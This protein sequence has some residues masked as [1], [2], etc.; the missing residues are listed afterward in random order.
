[1][2]NLSTTLQP[3]TD[4]ELLETGKILGQSLA[5][6]TIAGR[7][8]AAQ[9]AA[10]RQVRNDRTYTRSGLT[11]REF[12]SKHLKMSGAQADLIIRLLNEFGPD[13]FEL[14]QSIRIRPE[15][16]RLVAPYIKDNAL[17][18]NDEVLELNS[19]N[20]HN[21]AQSIHESQQALLPTGDPAPAE[22]NSS[23]AILSER[24]SELDQRVS[25]II[26]HF[27]EVGDDVR[28]SPA[29]QSMFQA[30]IGRM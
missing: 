25:E 24:L 4:D 15:K 14:T 12:S 19:A 26:G 8:S 28:H 13:Y 5:F 6:G 1:M 22:D 17:H 11:W 3:S 9:A 29:L 23:S 30:A 2:M 10:I 21:V 27:R 20:I 7:C 16:Y 18:F